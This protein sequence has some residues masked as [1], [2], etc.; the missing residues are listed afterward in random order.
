MNLVSS[1]TNAVLI[2]IQGRVTYST[3]EE[4]EICNR[5]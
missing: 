3:N 1:Y 2:L 4:R 5:E